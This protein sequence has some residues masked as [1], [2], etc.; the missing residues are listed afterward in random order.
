[1]KKLLVIVL[2]FFALTLTHAEN[3]KAF[4]WKVSTVEGDSDAATVYLM[5]SIHF[6][7]KSFY[8][9]RKE[10]VQAFDQSDYLVVELDINKVKPETYNNILLEKGI[11]KDGKTV[12]DV[13]T[14]E[15]LSQLRERLTKLNVSYDAVK[16]YKP[17]MLVLTLS[18]IQVTQMGFQPD[19][20]IDAYFLNK[21]AQQ[22]GKQIIEL[23]TLAQQ[24][25]LFIDI[26][27]SELLLKESLYSL[28]ESEVLMADMVRLWKQGDETKMNTLLF[29]D[30]LDDFPEFN[31]IYDSLFYARNNKMTSKIND[32]LKQQGSYFVVVGSGHLIGE[33]GIV[34]ALKE[35]GYDVERR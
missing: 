6:A 33:K 7:D 35:K 2:S 34:N 20:G 16:N 17:G 19:L 3:D 5:G 30:S 32:M 8:P 4:F 29:E 21:A 18:A 23:E 22:T 28:D 31:K 11:Y 12:E 26:P 27:D 13:L 15:T 9:L 24:L 10:I 25:D 14:K 1:M